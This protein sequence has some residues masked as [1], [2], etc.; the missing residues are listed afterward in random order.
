MSEI[1]TT[2]PEPKNG[3]DR[4]TVCV[5]KPEEI[6]GRA[7]CELLQ[8]VW[9]F[10]EHGGRLTCEVSARRKLGHGLEVPCIYRLTGPRKVVN[11][12]GAAPLKKNHYQVLVEPQTAALISVLLHQ[13]LLLLR[14]MHAVLLTE[15]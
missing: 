14:F 13:L 2:I 6:I 9:H 8:M 3:H 5:Q 15:I 7:P 1:S 4:Q 10:L 11:R 12:I